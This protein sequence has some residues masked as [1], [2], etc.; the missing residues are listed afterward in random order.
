MATETDFLEGILTPRMPL[1]LE[2]LLGRGSAGEVWKARSPLGLVAV[3]CLDLEASSEELQQ[4]SQEASLLRRIRHPNIVRFLDLVVEGG[5]LR[6]VM[7]LM[8]GDLGQAIT[9]RRERGRGGFG[10]EQLWRWLGRLASALRFLHQVKILHRDVKPANIFLSKTQ[11]AVLGDFSIAKVLGE[12]LAATQIG[13]PGY[14]A[15]EIWLGQPYGPKSDV[16][17][18]GCSIF[19]AAELRRAF[20]AIAAEACRPCPRFAKSATGVRRLVREMLEKTPQRRPGASEVLARAK[21]SARCYGGRSSAS[22]RKNARPHVVPP[23][24]PARRPRN[25]DV[26]VVDAPSLT[27]L[28]GWG[29]IC[30]WRDRVEVSAF[31]GLGEEQEVIDTLVFSSSEEEV[32]EDL[33]TLEIQPSTETLL[34]E[35]LLNEPG[36]LD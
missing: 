16:F 9:R 27:S 29:A 33:P 1:K 5:Q 7:Q 21:I 35:V 17:S 31:Y 19:E 14:L 25:P 2:S 3:K 30:P 4:A 26:K 28:G 32:E 18:L 12:D 24:S 13:T 20:T 36:V 23:L 6:M 8:E 15:P 22:P 10:E 34:K 11:D